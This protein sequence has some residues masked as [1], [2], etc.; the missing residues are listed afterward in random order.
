[1]SARNP[2]QPIGSGT[3]HRAVVNVKKFMEKA[4]KDGVNTKG[5]K[6]NVQD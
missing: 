2:Q 5:T 1:V 4:R 3:V 6:D